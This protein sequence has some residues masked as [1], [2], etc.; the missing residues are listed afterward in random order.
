MYMKRLWR[1]NEYDVFVG[2]GWNNWVR[3]S[4]NPATKKVERVKGV[5]PLTESLAKHVAA[6]IESFSRNRAA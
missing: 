6:R 4:Y 5:M 1:T 3:I 2:Q